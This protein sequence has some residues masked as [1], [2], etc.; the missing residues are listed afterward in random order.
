MSDAPLPPEEAER[1][2]EPANSQ[3]DSLE[4]PSESQ[5]SLQD[6]FKEFLDKKR[7]KRQLYRQRASSAHRTQ[8]ARDALRKRFLEIAHSYIG[9][10]YSRK[11]HPEG[12]ALR[13]APY[14]L[15]CCGLIRRVLYDM[16][17][18][19][20]FKPLPYNQSYQF[21]TLPDRYESHEQLKPGDLIFYA[22]EYFDPKKRRQKHDMVH[23][24]IYLGGEGTPERCLGSRF[25]KGVVSIFDSYRFP[26]T[27]WKLTKIYYVSIEPWLDG[28]CVS[29]CPQHNWEGDTSR[30]NK[31][32]VFEVLDKADLAPEAGED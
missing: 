25:R 26:S 21:D 10:P 13:N 6:A 16:Q 14:E 27:S 15:D 28:L 17:Y 30:I 32:S 20:G 19:L 12:S 1:G 11:E 7:K 24:E 23:V 29:S 3:Q 2:D 4:Q 31:Y 18:D 22:G 5:K 8:E 9:T